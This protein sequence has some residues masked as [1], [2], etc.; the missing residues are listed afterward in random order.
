MILCEVENISLEKNVY[1]GTQLC[2]AVCTGG[3]VPK[4]SEFN[5]DFYPILYFFL[6]HI[7]NFYAEQASLTECKGNCVLMFETLILCL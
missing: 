1:S 3:E 2:K 6:L 4:R 7:L 5:C